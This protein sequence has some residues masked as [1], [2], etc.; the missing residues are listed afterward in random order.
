VGLI[1]KTPI[2]SQNENNPKKKEDKKVV[3]T[4]FNYGYAFDMN[5]LHNNQ[6]GYWGFVDDNIE[7]ENLDGFLFGVGFNFLLGKYFNLFF[8]LN[9]VK[10][11]ILLG[12][13]GSYLHGPSIWG[14]SNTNMNYAIFDSPVLDRD[15]YYVSKTTYGVL[16]LDAK[17]PID[18]SITPYLG[19]GL[20]MASF[21]AGFGN[22]KGSRLYSDLLTGVE[23]FYLIRL[24]M[25]FNIY[26]KETK[27][28]SIGLYYERGRSVTDVSQE[29]TN[30]LW[31]GWTYR[32]QFI[33]VP[34]NRMGIQ[35]IF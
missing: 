30:W 13:T 10:S 16:G 21:Q 25:N 3:E 18:K 19:F 32:N 14:A 23:N 1:I 8:D 22:E 5:Y 35:L 28:F 17:F 2:Y 6:V 15:I 24:G 29:I 11:S 27:L 34:M 12:K 9:R 20:G 7:K 26:D 4:K 33:V 31:Q